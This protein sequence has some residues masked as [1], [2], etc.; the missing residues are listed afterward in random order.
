LQHFFDKYSVS[1]VAD[2]T[3][4]KEHA[5]GFKSKK[6]YEEAEL[7]ACVESFMAVLKR[8]IDH[9]EHYKQNKPSIIL[10]WMDMMKTVLNAQESI[11][12]IVSPKITIHENKE[13][14]WFLK[15]ALDSIQELIRRGKKEINRQRGLI[16]Q[17]RSSPK[18]IRYDT[19]FAL[20]T[21]SYHCLKILMVAYDVKSKKENPAET[22]KIISDSLYGTKNFE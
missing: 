7:Q 5:I 13:V 3:I 4:T 16:R 14:S 9:P 8:L 21:I 2:L 10:E 11:L 19:L 6:E 20:Q 17:R 12:K 18:Q 1:R 22:L 15:F